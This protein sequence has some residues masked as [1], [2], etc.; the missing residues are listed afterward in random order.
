MNDTA[1]TQQSAQAWAAEVAASLP[2]FTAAEA[3]AIGQL[4]AV[5]DARRRKA[6]A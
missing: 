3:A 1:S 2:P 6:A 4:A 5:I